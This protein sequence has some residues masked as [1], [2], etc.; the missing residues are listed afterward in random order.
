VREA[1]LPAALARLRAAASAVDGTVSVTLGP[2]T[3]FPPPSPVLYL[4]VGGDVDAL[5]TLRH[6]V[7]APPLQ[8]RLDHPFQPHVTL[9]TELPPDRLAAAVSAMAGYRSTATFDRLHLLE[10]R[11]VG[12]GGRVWRAV[13]DAPFARPVVTGTGG[14]PLEVAVT[15]LADPE[16]GAVLAAAGHGPIGSTDIV[17]AARREGRVV[18][19]AALTVGPSA[20]PWVDTGGRPARLLAITVVEDDRGTGVG[21]QLLEQ[22]ARAAAEV[23]STALV[24]GTGEP[25]V[26]AWLTSLGWCEHPRM[27][28][29]DGSW[30]PV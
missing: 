6:E 13:A 9:A 11:R 10:E 20:T 24:D 1:D 29:P 18:G 12:G 14:L 28:T 2:P 25:A 4:A 16:V 8:R 5:A 21:G 17:V 15:A 26:D 30:R 3:T 23:G 22:A 27:D 19:A 7:F